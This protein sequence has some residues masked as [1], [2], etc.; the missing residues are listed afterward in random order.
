MVAQL[1]AGGNTD[2][3]AAL[4]LPVLAARSDLA[5]AR[6]ARDTADSDTAKGSAVDTSGVS[7]VAVDAVSATAAR[8]E[9]GV[10]V[11]ALVVLGAGDSASGEAAGAVGV[12]AALGLGTEL[13][14][15]LTLA[16]G[17]DRD[18]GGRVDVDG[19]SAATEA[20]GLKTTTGSRVAPGAGAAAS[21]S[22]ASSEN[23]T[24]GAADGRGAGVG[25]GSVLVRLAGGEAGVD[26][27][28][29]GSGAANKSGT[30][31]TSRVLPSAGLVPGD[32]PVG[33]EEAEADKTT[34]ST[35]GGALLGRLDEVAV[36]SPRALVGTVAHVEEVDAENREGRRP[37]G[38]VVAGAGAAALARAEEDI[39]E[40]GTDS[41]EEVGTGRSQRGRRS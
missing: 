32:G 27:G 10:G 8:L 7:R 11:D 36:Q 40:E 33:L 41:V 31:E 15:E 30:G 4:E 38:V 2:A 24:A 29:A 28:D 12:V 37:D 3:L 21:N 17:D 9:L 14:L 18:L 35:S 25:E 6:D 16:A 26:V 34:L 23:S 13:S 1:L 19:G 20:T 5:L 39:A 22:G